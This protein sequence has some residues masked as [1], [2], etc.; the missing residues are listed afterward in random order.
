MKI[1]IS[2]FFIFLFSNINGQA[3]ADS[4]FN[5]GAKMYTYNKLDSAIE[6]VENGLNKYP[7]DRKLNELKKK[8]EE[9]QNKNN[10]SKKEE[11]NKDKKDG[12]DKEDEQK[13]GEDEKDE[14][15]KPEDKKEDKNKGD[16]EKEEQK[17]P[18]PKP[19]QLSPQQIKSLLEAMNNQEQKVQE[20]INA[21]KQKGVKIKTEK[22]W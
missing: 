6:I 21:E 19:G 17:K 3:S 10:N 4:Y 13:E 12:E 15:E 11:E 7:T 5:S 22:D 14:K 9:E 1:L 16:K 2:V 18:Q 8:L 20:K